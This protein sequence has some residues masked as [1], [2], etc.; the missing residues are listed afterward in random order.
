MSDTIESIRAQLR[1]AEQKV[2]DQRGWL[3]TNEAAT[4]MI[5]KERDAAL[6]RA[7]AAEGEKDEARKRSDRTHEWYEHQKQRADAA[8]EAKERAER[9]MVEM[10]AATDRMFADATAAE[11]ALREARKNYLRLGEAVSRAGPRANQLDVDL[12]DPETAT[13]AAEMADRIAMS[14]L[15]SETQRMCHEAMEREIARRNRSRL[16]VGRQQ[17]APMVIDNEFEV[18]FFAC[19]RFW[20]DLDRWQVDLVR[21]LYR[22]R[23]DAGG[24]PMTDGAA[25]GEEE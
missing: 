3:K 11:G 2:R 18:G 21:S 16:S 1:A 25:F 22:W 20:L 13:H 15:A 4:E 17:R 8:E 9:A 6:A 24:W 7:R 14:E 5:G 19:G 10:R 23:V 12:D